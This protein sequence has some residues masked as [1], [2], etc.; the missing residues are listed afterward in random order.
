MCHYPEVLHP[1]E[2][3]SAK[4]TRW[5]RARN[6]FNSSFP[7][8]QTRSSW[9]CA[10]AVRFVD[11]WWRLWKVA[12]H[13]GK[14]FSSFTITK[15]ILTKTPLQPVA[16]QPVFVKRKRRDSVN[17][18]SLAIL[19]PAPSTIESSSTLPSSRVRTLFSRLRR[20]QDSATPSE[21]IEHTQYPLVPVPKA[22]VEMLQISV[23]I[24]MPSQDKSMR[25][26]ALLDSTSPDDDDE[27]PLPEL[28]LGINKVSYRHKTLDAQ[29]TP[30][31]T[32]PSDIP[33][34]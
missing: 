21:G 28:A 17:L 34:S 2:T 11:L 1:Q 14:P 6:A 10:K 5:N 32:P 33:A 24:A 16:A 18:K 15:T 7:R 9:P 13:K 27:A 30:P 19:Q 12:R 25:K 22:R 31:S 4:S 8:L 3:A 29:S 23:L 20:Q 26:N